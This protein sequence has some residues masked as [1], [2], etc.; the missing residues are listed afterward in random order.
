MKK[1]I[2]IVLLLLSP[3]CLMANVP[4]AVSIGGPKKLSTGSLKVPYTC[5]VQGNL[6]GTIISYCWT[7][8]GENGEDYSDLFDGGTTN[9]YRIYINDAP[10]NFWLD[11]YM[12]YRSNTDSNEYVLSTGERIQ[13]MEPDFNVE[14]ESGLNGGTPTP[15][16]T[17]SMHFN[18]DDDD[19]SSVSGSLINCG[20]DYLQ[21]SYVVNNKEDDMPYIKITT[22]EPGLEIKYGRIKV[23]VSDN[24]KVWKT[25]NKGSNNLLFDESSTTEVN[26]TT[27]DGRALISAILKGKVYVEGVGLGNISISVNYNDKIVA[28]MPYQAFAPVAGR[29]PTR[30]E[31]IWCETAFPN[32]DGC[33]FS[34]KSDYTELYCPNY[35]CIAYSVL[36]NMSSNPSLRFWATDFFRS[37]GWEY[38]AHTNL[39]TCFTYAFYTHGGVKYTSVDLFGNQNRILEYVDIINF[40]SFYRYIQTYSYEDI[41]YFSAFHAARR[42]TSSE[43]LGF[44][45]RDYIVVSKCGP[46]P[47]IIHYAASVIDEYGHIIIKFRYDPI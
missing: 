11:V 37:S 39:M 20:Q 46:G 2:L 24:A 22:T 35:N 47:I 13:V 21:T 26:G 18:I 43:R 42:A 7:C 1:T 19:F 15:S 27:S 10:T 29:I 28:N 9:T 12:Y 6:N 23:V 30:E 3:L 17:I 25:K 8:M 33:E 16:S 45:D 34:I 14:R 4:L 44:Y 32:M 40:F 5:D 41:Y 38:S 36:P 31:R